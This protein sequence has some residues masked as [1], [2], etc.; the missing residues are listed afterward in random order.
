MNYDDEIAKTVKQDIKTDNAYILFY[1]KKNVRIK[2][3]QRTENEDL[4]YGKEKVVLPD[5]RVAQEKSTI[6]ETISKPRSRRGRKIS[7]KAKDYQNSTCKNKGN[8]SVSIRLEN[9]SEEQKDQNSTN[10]EAN[11]PPP[12]C[13]K[14]NQYTESGVLCDKCKRWYHFSCIPEDEDQI[15][16][17]ESYICADHDDEERKSAAADE[18]IS[19]ERDMGKRFL[20]RK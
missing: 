1:E 17:V 8:R 11:Q 12:E 14:C 16:L 9:I 6:E 2:P 5:D 15:L 20:I 3:G 10:N 13:K 18:V 4:T 7:E 19:S